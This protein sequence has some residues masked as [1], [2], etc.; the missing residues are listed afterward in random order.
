MWYLICAVD[1]LA[2]R[3]HVVRGR[4]GQRGRGGHG[5]RDPPRPVLDCRRGVGAARV[6]VACTIVNVG[7]NLGDL[8]DL[9][10]GEVDAVRAAN[11]THLEFCPI[12]V[13]RDAF[14]LGIGTRGIRVN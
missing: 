4:R 6:A 5:L 14:E 9:G 1:C 7:G 12:V 8:F 3:Q 10:G 2:G 11:R 13:I